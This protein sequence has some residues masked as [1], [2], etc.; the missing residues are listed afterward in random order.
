MSR[1][2]CATGLALAA[3][4]VLWGCARPARATFGPEE[5]RREAR[6]SA[7]HFATAVRE[8][9]F[10]PACGAP[11]ATGTPRHAVLVNARQALSCRDLGY[12]LRRLVPAPGS[13]PAPW[14]MVPAADT[15]AI[16]PFLR[17]ERVRLPVVAI[18]AG[19]DLREVRTIVLARLGP[20]GPDTTYFAPTGRA[21]LLQYQQDTL[22]R[23]AF[24]APITSDTGA[25]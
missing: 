5:Q 10:V 13:A 20:G 6:S 22:T 14:I 24:V 25:R 15:A 16:C 12:L 3:A 1:R 11:P 21:V 19:D 7:D 4:T 2:L 17:Q 9:A 23:S 8:R 18:T